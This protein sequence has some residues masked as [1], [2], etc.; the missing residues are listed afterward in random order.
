MTLQIKYLKDIPVAGSQ[1]AESSSSKKASK[2]IT[3][4][5]LA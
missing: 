5:I 4:D 3:I 1:I 2:S